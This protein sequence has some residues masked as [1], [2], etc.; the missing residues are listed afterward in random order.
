MSV[1]GWDCCGWA[2]KNDLLCSDGRIIKRGAF[3]EQDGTT[4]P[5]VYQHRHDSI[6]NVLGH[7][8]LENRDDGVFAYA[9]FND[10]P[11]GRAGKEAVEH[12]DITSFSIYANKLK[13]VGPNVVHGAIRELSLVLTGANPGACITNVSMSHGED[14]EFEGVIYTGEELSE[15]SGNDIR[16]SA[17]DEDETVQD[18]FNTLTDKQKRVVYYLIQQAVGGDEEDYDD[19]FAHSD[20]EY[21][22]DDVEAVFDTL[23]DKQKEAVYQIIGDTVADAIEAEDDDD[24]EYGDDADDD[25]EYGDDADDDDEYGD[26]E[27]GDDADEYDDSVEHSYTEGDMRYNNVFDNSMDDAYDDVLT[28]AEE[29]TI[30]E[31]MK[32]TGS[33]KE[34]V[35]AHADEYG[36]EQIDYLFPDF[37]TLSNT[38]EFIRRDNTWVGVVMNG[39][40]RTPFARI[41]T[42]NADITEDAARAKGY[43]KGNLKKDEVFTLLKRTTSPTTVYKKQRFDRDDLTDITNMDTVAWVKTEMREMLDEEIARAI[44]FSD[45]RSTSDDDKIS[46]AN[47]RPIYNDAALYTINAVVPNGADDVETAKNAIKTLV[48]AKT[49]Y[50]G[51]GTLIFFAKDTLITEMLLLEDTIGHPLYKSEAELASKLRVSRIVTVPAEIIPQGIYGVA[52]DLKDYNVGADKGGAVNMFDDFDIDYNQQKYLIETRISGALIKPYS[53]IVLKEA[54]ASGGSDNNG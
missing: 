8:L 10:T 13:Q 35:L 52:V 1:T 23:T 44:L 16:H 24:D 26:D 31:D 54:P 20:D 5:L 46:E 38:P 32:R 36:I 37:Q 30:F 42:I 47:V 40:H 49:K 9:Y 3:A 50:R 51:S 17:Y 45:L 15:V 34:S 4:V 39:V 41:K 53:A 28:H 19:D 29:A 43:M 25:D 22:D 12:G 48:R 18:V 11:Q 27:Y 6:E 21:D 14:G 2:T 33:L 7:A